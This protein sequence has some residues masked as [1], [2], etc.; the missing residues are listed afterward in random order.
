MTASVQDVEKLEPLREALD[1]GARVA[2]APSQRSLLERTAHLAKEKLAPRASHYDETATFPTEDFQDLFDARLHAAAVP[3]QYGGLGLGP[4]QEDVFTLWMITKELAKADLS[5][6]RCWEG[7]ANSMVMLSGMANEEQKQRWYAGVVER[8]DIWVAWSGEPQTRT[9]DQ[10]KKFGTTVTRVDGGFIVD[11]TKIFASSA[12]GAQWAILLVSTEGPGGARHTS[13]SP[14]SVLLLACELSDPSVT[15]DASWWDPIGMRGSVSHLV[16]FQ[17]T[18]VPETDSIG[19]PGQYLREGWQTCFTPQY[20]SSFLGAAQAAYEHAMEHLATQSRAGDPYVQHHVGQMSVNIE[21]GVL[22]LRHVAQLWESGDHD[23]ARLAGVKARYVIESLAQDTVAHCIK[24]CGARSLIRPSP[25]ER[26][27]RDLSFYV[28][29][30]SADQILA[31]IGRS[32]FGESHDVS[33]FK[34]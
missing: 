29:H 11:G 27:Y 15:Y 6:A 31:T 25:I 32:A 19:Y 7:H 33:F 4:F 21:T 16:R 2:L 30:D 14:D 20:G 1:L 28:C 17:R 24:A 22:W 3:K 34:T 9:P 18:F 8:G 10:M 13:G 26:I 12:G 23:N 5:L